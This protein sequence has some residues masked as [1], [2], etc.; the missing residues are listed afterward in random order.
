VR[1]RLSS[2]FLL[3]LLCIQ[4]QAAQNPAPNEFP[5]EYR[6]GM[7][8][9][10]VRTPKSAE[11]LSFLLDSGAGVSVINLTTAQRLGL[12]LA[13]RIEVQGVRSTSTGYFPQRLSASVAGVALPKQYVAVDLD[14]L[15]D[16]CHCHVDG[17]LGADFFR[18]RTV[19]IDF[20]SQKVRLLSSGA[21]LTAGEILPLTNNRN[22]FLTPLTV[23]GKEK[24]WMRVDTGCA[25]ALQWVTT[26]A[27]ANNR[28][29]RIAIALKE[30]SLDMVPVAVRIG[31]TEIPSLSAEIHEAPMFTGEDGILGNGLLARFR[32][33]TIDTKAR[34]LILEPHSAAQ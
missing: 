5:F 34:R 26:D 21:P 9:I 18:D 23:N 17:L 27:P 12:R 31:K 28:S 2:I 15:S 33:V 24:Q 20:A 25:S 10:E 19:Q 11:P 8:W 16:A 6:E 29:H 3:S 1:T 7:I 4:A 13:N 32:S 30:V 22:A 14:K